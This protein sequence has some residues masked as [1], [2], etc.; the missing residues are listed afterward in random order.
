M[1]PIVQIR[2]MMAEQ[3][4]SEAQRE[5]EV[6]LQLNLVPRREL[7][8]LYY[9]VAVNLNKDLPPELCLELSEIEMREKNYDLV[10][11]LIKS[12][13]TEKHF[14]R[15]QK[16]KCTVA[17]DKG[18]M[19]ELYTHLSDFLLHQFERQLPVIPEFITDRIHKYFRYDFNLK[20][21]QL[22]LMMLID[23]IAGAEEAT[24]ELITSTIERSSPKGVRQ[25]MLAIAEV[26]KTG[27]NQKTQLKIYHSFCLI[28]ADGIASSADYK[29]LL[30]MVIYF[31]D[32]KF[33]ALLLNLLHKQNLSEEAVKYAESVRENKQYSFVYFDKYFPE[34]KNYF[35]QSVKKSAKVVDAVFQPDLKLSEKPYSM[36]YIS[37]VPEQEL[38]PEEDQYLHLLKYQSYSSDQLCDLA[39]S[40]LQSEMPGVALRASELAIKNAASD[41]DFLKGSYL[42]LISQ[43]KL[44][45]YRAA[46]DTCFVALEKAESRDDILSFMYGQAEAYIRLEQKK[47][48]K[49]VLSKIISIDAGY[50]LAKER[51]EKLNEI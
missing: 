9:E 11:S 50:R 49:E 48:A 7:L 51:L 28:S 16:I 32:F 10:S 41:R 5:I 46:V 31:D 38:D 42:R 40:F 25:K 14:F 20:L 27:K 36:E 43:L 29:R 6:Q 18:R 24:K 35:V 21:K 3:K 2:Q 22:A 39:V 34:L 12:V 37:S 44:G 4:F 45:D 47:N 30:E 23:D 15:I 26:L 17:E 8:L 33:Q 19:E 1:D 13:R